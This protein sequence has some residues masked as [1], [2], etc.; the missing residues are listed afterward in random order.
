[1]ELQRA[2]N[3]FLLQAGSVYLIQA[4]EVQTLGTVSFLLQTGFYYAQVL[5][6]MGCTGYKKGGYETAS[7]LKRKAAISSES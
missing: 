4:L 6:K 1:M 7:N 5:F 2:R 3:F